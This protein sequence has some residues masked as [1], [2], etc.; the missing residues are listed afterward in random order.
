MS[1]HI[2]K[3]SVIDAGKTKRRN[4]I[5]YVTFPLRDLPAENEQTLY[6]MDLEKVGAMVSTAPRRNNRNSDKLYGGKLHSN[7][8]NSVKFFFVTW[9][10]WRMGY[11]CV[12]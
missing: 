3:L 10:A 6:K 1:D 7:L 12:S 11:I 4:V 9:H 8:L 5:G 2:L